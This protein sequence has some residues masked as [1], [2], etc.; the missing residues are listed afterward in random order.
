MTDQEARRAQQTDGPLPPRPSAPGSPLP[1]MLELREEVKILAEGLKELAAS[2]HRLERRLSDSRAEVRQLSAG[3]SDK[4]GFDQRLRSYREA[5]KFVSQVWPEKDLMGPRERIL[6]ELQ[7][8]AYLA[9]GE[10][11][12]ISE[13]PDETADFR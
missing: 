12:S 3:T 5:H 10:P 1:P 13:K 4:E 9:V 11:I 6:T 8:A 2:H 7:V